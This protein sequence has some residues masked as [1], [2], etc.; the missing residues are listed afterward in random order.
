[1]GFFPQ[2]ML[3]KGRDDFILLV[4]PKRDFGLC[5]SKDQGSFDPRLEQPMLS[6]FVSPLPLKYY[7]TG[8][9]HNVWECVP[10]SRGLP[11]LSTFLFDNV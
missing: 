7:A 2:E 10:L 5:S 11:S 9:S 3:G 6:N 8:V 4:F 1:M